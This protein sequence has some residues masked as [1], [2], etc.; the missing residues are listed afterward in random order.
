MSG[1]NTEK[2]ASYRAK[3][4]A[5]G[6]PEPFAGGAVAGGNLF[7]VQQHHARAKHYDLRL[8]IDGV[9]VSWAVPK[10]PAPDPAIRRFA[11]RTED[12]PLEY[13]DFEGR[14]PEGN[15]GAGS[16]IVWDRGHYRA[17]EPLAAGLAEG[18]LL[19]DLH[20]AKLHGRWT[21]VK[22]RRDERDWLLIKERDGHARSAGT[23]DYPPTSVLSGLT[24]EQVA[25]GHDPTAGLVAAL[26]RA[27][28][29]RR[30]VDP[31]RVAVM[32]AGTAAPFSA[33]DW[34][35]ELKYDGYRLLAG[36][37]R[38]EVLLRSRAGNELTASFP[39]VAFALSRLPYAGLV[40][41]GEV[42]VH[43]ARG[44]PDFSRLQQR[45]RST[46][47][48]DV[49]AASVRHPAVYYAFDLLAAAGYDLRVLPLRMRKALLRR[50]LPDPGLI[51]Y[52]DHVER[53]GE[54]LFEQTAAMGL[55][56]VI[57]KRADAPYRGGR[58]HDWLK[59]TADRRAD[60][61]VLGYTAGNAAGDLGA[62]L[63]GQRDG[64]QVR[65]VG[66][67]GSGFDARLRAQLL[68]RLRD[69][70][71]AT[72]PANAPHR[73][74]WTWRRSGLCCEVRYKEYSADGLLRQPV[75]LRL[76][77]DREPADC[78]WRDR[79][80]PAAPPA[81]AVPSRRGGAGRVTAQPPAAG[82][83]ADAVPVTN[84]DKVFWPA[85]G[86][87]KGDLVDYY[88]RVS[89]WLLP[90]LRDRPVVL[91]RYPDGI[92]GKSFFQKDA[93]AHA[94]DWLRRETLWSQ[95]AGREVSYFVVED[96]ASLAWIINLGTIPLH[97]W[98][99]RLATLE[100][101]DW[102]VLDLDPKGAPFADVVTIARFIEGLCR[103]V[104]LPCFVKTTGSSGLHVLV[105]LGRQL[106]Y[107]QSRTLAELLARITVAALPQI[108]TVTRAV[109]RRDD[110]VYIDTLQNGHGRLLVAP[111]SVRALPGAPVSMPLA[112]REVGPRLDTRRYTLANALRRLAALKR[113]PWA[114]MLD[115]APDLT[116]VLD[117]M[118]RRWQSVRRSAAR[119]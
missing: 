68:A 58:S 49:A 72:P 92:D 98:A 7:V 4:S 43:D 105:P 10:G 95:H 73:V 37:D 97:I 44:L 107:E 6:T 31:R 103:E 1:K 5:D 8:E 56:G 62:L 88:R 115:V 20:G 24:V 27:G 76:R 34:I 40:L 86:Y 13:A 50:V 9:L 65:Y 69:A 111:Y 118:Q 63:L 57:A 78:T 74:D 71:P 70:P 101:P 110:K 28:A 51:R 61:E 30:P 54:A 19:F 12:H 39:E 82:V 89:P 47:R 104:S 15:Y 100:R 2:L 16:V 18:K 66:R 96:E 106:T 14:I 53:Q 60:C 3:R 45:A 17:V 38:G 117:R 42:V 77:D 113:D 55:E 32:L 84:A 67:V 83:A 116:A 87:T 23:A 85:E 114:G 33:D 99:S 112:W 59:I 79:E 81:E 52:A 48:A 109:E 108:A 26:R 22:T 93:P 25:A 35:F 36:A 11:V 119:S 64:E 75:F 91:T 41:D 94:P 90:W 46:R 21:L 102:S 29:L 80:A